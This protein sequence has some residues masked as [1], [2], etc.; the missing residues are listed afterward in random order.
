V[1]DADDKGATVSASEFQVTDGTPEDTGIPQMV[2]FKGAIPLPKSRPAPETRSSKPSPLAAAA[3][4]RARAK[5]A[6]AA[7]AA[8]ARAQTAQNPFT[9][10]E[11]PPN[12]FAVLLGTGP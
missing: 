12:P 2:F 3:R 8:K 4:A 1:N 9:P 7:R 6:K 10:A 5:A 11:P